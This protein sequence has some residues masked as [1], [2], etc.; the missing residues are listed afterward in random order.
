[1][2]RSSAR[3]GWTRL[4]LALLGLLVVAAPIAAGAQ[5]VMIVEPRGV[6]T[7]VRTAVVELVRRE[8]G[9][10]VVQG[11]TSS[12]Q[13]LAPRELAELAAERD[14]RFA[15][16]MAVQGK[17]LCVLAVDDGGTIVLERSVA[18]PKSSKK[19]RRVAEELARETTAAVRDRAQQARRP[20]TASSADSG[21]RVRVGASDPFAAGGAPPWSSDGSSGPAPLG[22]EAKTEDTRRKRREGRESGMRGALTA[23]GGMFG[24]RDE[25]D[26]TNA[27]GDRTIA[28][29]MTP[30]LS[31]GLGLELGERVELEVA[32]YRRA[33]VLRPRVS[34]GALEVDSTTLG[35]TGTVAW[36]LTDSNVAIAALAGLTFDS[37]SVGAQTDIL[38]I[39]A[40]SLLAPLV[41]MSV[42]TGSL[43]AT[44]LTLRV[45]LAALPWGKHVRDVGF[46]VTSRALGGRAWARA[47]YHLTD[48]GGSMGLFVDLGASAQ[49]LTLEAS[50]SVPV[51]TVDAPLNEK[52]LP[53]GR[54][55]ASHMT[56][57][58]GLAFGLSFG[59]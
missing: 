50:S 1:M 25:I 48:V 8:F 41:G 23:G 22:G 4:S 7:K 21:N 59:G 27:Y 40:Q 3:A 56:Y 20:V 36:K 58:G 13:L 45:G 43:A 57:G 42:A 37:T 28:V 38:W 46:E 47:R 33:A 52:A 32:A 16:D 30:Q 6:S 26:S 2:I 15:I 11:S 18:L 29:Q 44:G 24:W 10:K 14:A 51:P 39:P 49:Y 53:S 31:F 19:H 55:G 5:A 35:G 17:R 12:K 34:T 54:E 9:S